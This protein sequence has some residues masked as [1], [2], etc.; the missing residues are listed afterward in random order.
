MTG[1]GVRQSG[2]VVCTSGPIRC[3]GLSGYET[4]D[5][6]KQATKTVEP[7]VATDER[8]VAIEVVR[9]GTAQIAN[10]TVRGLRG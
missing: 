8:W 1:S 10:A 5:V 7:R 9:L 2:A 4:A 6:P 3:A